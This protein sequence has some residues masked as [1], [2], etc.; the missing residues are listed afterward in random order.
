MLRQCV[1]WRLL[2]R[3]PLRYGRVS[4]ESVTAAVR[5]AE[6]RAALTEREAQKRVTRVQEKS[7]TTLAS[8]R[9]K[10]KDLAQ[11]I[12]LLEGKLAKALQAR[13]TAE[14]NSWGL[15]DKVAG[16]V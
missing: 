14:E 16:G 5:D 13:D 7:A 8:A 4:W 10:A 2:P 3:R 15:S 1:L 12:A 11:R 9:G 6:D